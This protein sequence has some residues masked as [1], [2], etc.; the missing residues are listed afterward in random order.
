MVADAHYE[1]IIT[2]ALAVVSGVWFD[3][4][5]CQIW[6]EILGLDGGAGVLPHVGNVSRWQ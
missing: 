2:H 1:H 3:D 4:R 6:Q 5:K